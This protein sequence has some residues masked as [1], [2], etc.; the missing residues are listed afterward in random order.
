MPW[1]NFLTSLHVCYFYKFMK[2]RYN[3]LSLE[4]SNRRQD[5]QWRHLVS[6]WACWPL[7]SFVDISTIEQ[8]YGDINFFPLSKNVMWHHIFRWSK[9]AIISL[10]LFNY[11]FFPWKTSMVAQAHYETWLSSSFILS[12]YMI[13]TSLED[14]ISSF[15]NECQ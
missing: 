11:G 2:K 14:C 13:F 8:L 15:H 1:L 9:K 3:L 12:S 5:G 10:K 6:Y 7:K 4:I